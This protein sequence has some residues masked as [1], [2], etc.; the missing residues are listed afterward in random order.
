[1]AANDQPAGEDAAVLQAILAATDPLS[2]I[3]YR[4]TRTG[5]HLQLNELRSYRPKRAAEAAATTIRRPFDAAK[6]NFNRVPDEAFWTGTWQGHNLA[7][8]Y[9]KYPFEPYHVVLV[10][11]PEAGQEQFLRP[12]DH[13]TAWEVSQSLSHVE[14]G[15]VVAYNALGAFASVNHLHF[16]M[17]FGGHDLPILSADLANYPIL[18]HEHRQPEAAWREIHQL[19]TANQPFHVLYAPGRILVLPRR[20]QGSYEQPEWTTGFAWYELS[21]NIILVNAP[22][23]ESL[24]D[25]QIEHALKPLE[26][27]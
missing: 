5:W 10:P 7:C 24:T 12:A 3:H 11:E 13:D 6:F 17:I 9:N 27:H 26:V 8:F 22:A 20:F 1:L 14:P 16:Q 23:F 18:V 15:V 4:T 25:A 19:Q 21:G 2:L